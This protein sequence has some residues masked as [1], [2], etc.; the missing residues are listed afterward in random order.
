M[1]WFYEQSATEGGEY[2]QVRQ[3]SWTEEFRDVY[4]RCM[5]TFFASA[6]LAAPEAELILYT[7]R[8]FDPQASEVSATLAAALINLDVSVR[9]VDYS[10]APP[11]TWTRQWR[12]QFFVFDVMADIARTV[13]PTDAVLILDSDIVWTRKE[14]VADLTEAIARHGYLT[15]AID[16]P[17]DHVVNSLSTRDLLTV[18]RALD[19]NGADTLAYSGGEFIALRGDKLQELSALAAQTWPALMARHESGEPNISEE[20]HYLS[21]LYRS[22]GFEPGGGNQFIKRL[23]TQPLKHRNVHTSDQ[24][25]LLWHL[26][27][28][29]KYGIRRVYESL[30]K[31]DYASH[32]TVAPVLNSK[33]LGSQLGIPSNTPRKWLLDVSSVTIRRI[34]ERIL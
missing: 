11:E 12:N 23:W 4:R 20:A 1:T 34:K 31:V 25:L 24:N 29:K 26:P 10:Y 6:R 9:N 21:H 32:E 8:P 14:P 28:E 15:Y 18:S 17:P 27:A 2:A 5:L 13:N 3:A 19:P 7:N 16:Y 30:L 33:N 22:M